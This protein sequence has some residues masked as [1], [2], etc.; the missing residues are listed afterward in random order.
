MICL[1][2]ASDIRSFDIKTLFPWGCLPFLLHKIRDEGEF[3]SI[4]NWWPKCC[5]KSFVFTW[6]SVLGRGVYTCI[7]HEKICDVIRY[8]SDPTSCI[9]MIRMTKQSCWVKHL[10]WCL[11]TCIRSWMIRVTNAFCQQHNLVPMGVST[12]A[13]RIVHV[14][15]IMKIQYLIGVEG[16]SF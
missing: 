4:Y 6:L 16:D 13:L 10:S 14:Y 9:Q 12:F 8:E 3:S 2:F 15:K 7:N 5:H 1:K 11:Y